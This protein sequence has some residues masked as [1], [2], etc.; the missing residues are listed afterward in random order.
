MK[1][2]DV[3]ASVDRAGNTIN[4]LSAR[5]WTTALNPTQYGWASS[6]ASIAAIPVL[7]T[8]SIGQMVSA[9]VVSQISPS[10]FDKLPNLS[11]GKDGGGPKK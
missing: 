2:E 6:I 4:D 11:P 1:K 9:A 7:S 5:V 8:A 10:V 3:V